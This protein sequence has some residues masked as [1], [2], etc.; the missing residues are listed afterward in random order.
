[1]TGEDSK[2]NTEELAA[3][4]PIENL[5]DTGDNPSIS[6]STSGNRIND[7]LNEQDQEAEEYAIKFLTS[8]LRLRGVRV[9]REH[10][11]RTELHK[12]GISK[13][14]IG[15]AIQHSPAAAGLNPVLLDEIAKASIDFERNKSST[16]SFAAGV[17]GGFAMLATVPGDIT[18]FYVHVFR[19]MQKLAYVYGWQ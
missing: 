8:V 19:V 14:E 9:E 6:A 10:F 12:R 1:M 7:M 15:Q 13:A 2:N 11:L 16:L 3:R 17:P 4:E 18:Q 5:I